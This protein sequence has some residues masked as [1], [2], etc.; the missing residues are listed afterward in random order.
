MPRGANPNSLANLKGGSRKGIP[1][2]A[3]TEIKEIARG[4]LADPEYQDALR[5]RLRRGDAGAVEVTLY[6][7]AY[8]KP[9]ETQDVNVSGGLVFRWAGDGE[10][11]QPGD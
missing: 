5:R 10:H 7:Y 11:E 6:H 4:L 2:R 9:R 8:G 3:T 1:N